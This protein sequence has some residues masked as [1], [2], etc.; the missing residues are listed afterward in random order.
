M[1]YIEGST[2][3]TEVFRIVNHINFK[4]LR[5]RCQKLLSGYLSINLPKS[6]ISN[7]KKLKN[8]IYK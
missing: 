8:N 3:N 5:F 2:G 7:F 4:F 1:L 6:E